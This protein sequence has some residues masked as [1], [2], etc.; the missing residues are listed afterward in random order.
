MSEAKQR[1]VLQ[2][3]RDYR[4]F[5][6][7][8]GGAA[9]TDSTMNLE[10]QGS[11]GP[12][13]LIFAGTEFERTDRRLLRQS[14]M[15]LARGLDLLKTQESVGTH[16]EGDNIAGLSAF[17]AFIEPYLADPADPSVVGDWRDKAARG[18][19][20]ARRFV[21]RHDA[22]VAWLASHEP[23]SSA[24]LHAVPPKLMSEN[25]EAKIEHQYAE[26]YAVFQR[27][28][29]SG[30]RVDVAKAQAADYFEVP[31]DVIE[32]VVEFRSRDKQ[33]ECSWGGCDRAPFSQNLCVA[34]Y[35]KKRR[36]EK[37]KVS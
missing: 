3:L 4:A 27:L 16:T 1:E 26:M 11:F 22:G 30:L 6:S 33:D 13:G 32:R 10:E 25:E 5:V 35:N 29:V 28:R 7:P 14:F 20:G 2:L 17:I 37:K 24:D 8:F 9:P 12:A 31:V 18:Y 34:H 36:A 21:E 19:V 15:I 23:I